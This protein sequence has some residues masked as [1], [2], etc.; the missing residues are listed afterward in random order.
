[1]EEQVHLLCEERCRDASA[2]DVLQLARQ[3]LRL[4]DPT[5][6]SGV[7]DLRLPHYWQPF[8]NAAENH[9]EVP[10][11]RGS[12]EWDMVCTMMNANIHQHGGKYGRVPG[13]MEDPRSFPVVRIG[14]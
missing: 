9:V 4:L 13:S 8:A 7:D 12:S 3:V 1:M 10:I 5:S 14:A 6:L 11:A 2:D